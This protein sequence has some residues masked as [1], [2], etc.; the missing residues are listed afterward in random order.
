MKVKILIALLAIVSSAFAKPV[1]YDKI[2]TD[3]DACFLLYSVNKHKVVAKYNPKN[4]C[5]KQ[6][7]PNSTFKIPLSLM[8]FDQKIITESTVFIWDG[9]DTGMAAWKHNQNQTPQTWI[10]NSVVWVS[11]QITPKLGVAKIKDYLNKFNYGNQDFSGDVGK[12]N[13]LTNAWLSSSLKISALEQLKFLQRMDKGKLPV[14]S[15]AVYHTE[16][17]MSL[18]RDKKLFDTWNTDGKTGSGSR[19]VKVNNETG[20]IRHGWFVGY[21]KHSGTT[22]IF[23]TNIMDKAPVKPNKTKYGGQ[24]A[25]AATVEIINQHFMKQ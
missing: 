19:I 16:L 2:F 3:V 5:A 4:R 18:D 1:A 11:Q 23:V 8:A 13:G 21:L 15:D 12:T 20:K 9:K 17:N 22:Y 25:K 7:A 24:I 10:Q 14:S 6:I